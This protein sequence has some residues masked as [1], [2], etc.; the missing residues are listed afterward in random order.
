MSITNYTKRR[1]LTA[2]FLEEF[3]ENRF[4]ID[5]IEDRGILLQWWKNIDMDVGDYVEIRLYIRGMKGYIM[6][7]MKGYV[8]Y[9]YIG[10]RDKFDALVGIELDEKSAQG[11]DGTLSG[12]NYFKCNEGHGIFVTRDK[13][14][15]LVK[16]E[17]MGCMIWHE[18][19]NSGNIN[20]ISVLKL[21][22]ICQESKKG[23]ISGLILLEYATNGIL[24]QIPNDIQH[25]AWRQ[26]IEHYMP[27]VIER[28]LSKQKSAKIVLTAKKNR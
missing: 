24:N 10:D 23:E 7:R 1:R 16:R 2:D 17:Q 3:L 4:A 9:R 5:E 27:S 8:R 6:N 12:R 25:I 21:R 22:K 20:K 28:F 19:I 13:I 15:I 26:H 14:K 18:L 11:N